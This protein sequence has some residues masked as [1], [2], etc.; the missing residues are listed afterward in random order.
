MES[1]INKITA[2]NINAVLEYLPYF[3]DPSNEF[4][5][6]NMQSVTGPYIYSPKIN[7]FVDCLHKNGFVRGFDINKWQDEATKFFLDKTAL[8]NATID[9]LVKL[10]TMHIAKESN[11]CGH[12]ASMINEGHILN[13]L[14]RLEAIKTSGQL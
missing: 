11:N 9:D 4:Y 10:F 12:L 1:Q 5:I 14:K 8:E 7:S 2:D 3:A 13:I 6:N